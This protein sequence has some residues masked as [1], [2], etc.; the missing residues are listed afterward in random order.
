VVFDYD[1]GHYQE[2][3]PD[4]ST[5]ANQQHQRVRASDQP[6]HSW[7]ARPDP[8]S[9][10]SA[11]FEVRT[12]RRCHR[13]LMFHHFEELGN[14]PCLVRSTDFDYADLDYAQRVSIEAELAHEGSTRFA[15]FIRS[16]TQSG[17]TRQPDGS[18]IRKS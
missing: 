11:G 9:R 14:E 2:L 17:Y 10:Y 1:E 5:P 18:Y 6:E 3:D 15:S 7:M 4:P 12:Y 8:F 16:V 13:V